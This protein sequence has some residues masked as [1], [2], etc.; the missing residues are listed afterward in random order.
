MY[1]C[2]TNRIQCY[3]IHEYLNTGLTINFACALQH[4]VVNDL[5]VKENGNKQSYSLIKQETHY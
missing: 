1:K 4:F 2:I 3:L 5:L